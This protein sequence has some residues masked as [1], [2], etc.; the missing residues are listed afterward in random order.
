MPDESSA[1]PKIQPFERSPCGQAL[2]SYTDIEGEAVDLAQASGKKRR[3][4]S[5]PP[6]NCSYGTLEASEGRATIKEM[7]SRAPALNA[8]AASLDT[9]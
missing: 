5:G 2:F 1:A 6:A 4:Y 7:L 3:F 9:H 8:S